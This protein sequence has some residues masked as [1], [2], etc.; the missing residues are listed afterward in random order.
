MSVA[1]DA[2]LVAHRLRERL[3]QGDADILHRVMG[4]DMQIAFGVHF[5]IHHPMT[6]DLVEHVLEEGHAGLEVGLAAAVEIH[7][8]R[9]LRLKGVACDRCLAF[10]HCLLRVFGGASGAARRWKGIPL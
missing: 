6:G 1:Q 7:A 2:L 10:S 3:A 4:I 5:D 8:D 9:D